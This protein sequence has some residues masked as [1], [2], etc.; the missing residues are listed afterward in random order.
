MATHVPTDPFLAAAVISIGSSIRGELLVW[1]G[2]PLTVIGCSLATAAAWSADPNNRRADTRVTDLALL[3]MAVAGLCAPV[4]VGTVAFDLMKRAFFGISFVAIAWR[5]RMHPALRR[6]TITALWALFVLVHT[7]SLITVPD[8]MIDNWAWTQA[9]LRAFTHGV[10]PYTLS[11][12]DVPGAQF[13][14]D[15]ISAFPYPPLTLVVLAPAYLVAGD[16]RIALVA[17]AVLMIPTLRSLGRRAQLDEPQLQLATLLVLL[18]PRGFNF[19]AF[20]HV[21]PLMALAAMSFAYFARDARGAA[22]EATSFWML[23]GLKQYMLGPALVYALAPHR[24]R[25]VVFATGL[26]V[27]AVAVPFFAWNAAATWHGLTVEAAEWVAPDPAS[28]SL[29][30]LSLRL[31]WWYPNRYFSAA[32]QL[33]VSGLFG[34]RLRTRGAGG[35]LLGSSVAL[36]A[37]FLW[38]WQAYPHYFYLVSMMLVGGGVALANN[39]STPLRRS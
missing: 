3:T 34:W 6:H 22:L 39:G 4:T 1:L 17:A 13:G 8:P 37:T 20:G 24:R 32:I 15:P 19:T 10:H 21:E 35:V 18:Q 7:A 31:G 28:T 11:F 12:A 5:A 36:L 27:A 2:I 25:L 29:I 38:G 26:S 16:Y 23:P 30:A 14:R 33:L 9:C